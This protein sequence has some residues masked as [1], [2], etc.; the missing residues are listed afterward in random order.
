MDK[1]TVKMVMDAAKDTGV[2]G[3]RDW[4]G[5]DKEKE[6]GWPWQVNYFV[7]THCLIINNGACKHWSFCRKKKDGDMEHID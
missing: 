1:E 2:R 5:S 3:A 6:C 4:E 7:E